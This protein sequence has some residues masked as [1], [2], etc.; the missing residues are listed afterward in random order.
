MGV[1]FCD[2]SFN[3]YAIASHFDWMIGIFIYFL[4]MFIQILPDSF[5]QSDLFFYILFGVFFYHSFALRRDLFRHHAG[6]STIRAIAI[7]QGRAFHARKTY[8]S[9]SIVVFKVVYL[10]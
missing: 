1:D 4:Y 5:L 3:I 8:H 6:R 10:F 2:L 9:F 7:W